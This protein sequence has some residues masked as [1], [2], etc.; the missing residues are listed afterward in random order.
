MSGRSGYVRIEQASR[1]KPKHTKENEIKLQKDTGSLFFPQSTLSTLQNRV[2]SQIEKEILYNDETAL[3]SQDEKIR[4]RVGYAI[5]QTPTIPKDLPSLV[6]KSSFRA[7]MDEKSSKCRNGIRRVFGIKGSENTQ[8]GSKISETTSTDSN[9]LD[10]SDLI[11]VQIQSVLSHSICRSNTTT[12]QL[13]RWLGNRRL[14]EPWGKLGKDPELFDPNGDTLIYFCDAQKEFPRPPPSFR[15]NS[16]IIEAS[17][18][19]VL[20][21]LLRAS[22]TEN[23]IHAA[24]DSNDQ[25]CNNMSTSKVSSYDGLVSYEIFFPA[26]RELSQTEV[27]RH[28][29]T[30]RNV[31][32]LLLNASLVGE[33]IYQ[34]LYDLRDR[35]EEYM[36]ANGDSAG[37]II[38]WITRRGIDDPRQNPSTALSFLAWTE[39]DGVRWEEGW[40]EAYCHAVGMRAIDLDSKFEFLPE[41]GYLSSITK[42]LLDRSSMELQLLVR[43]CEYRLNTFDFTDM[44]SAFDHCGPST[45]TGRSAFAR[46]RKFFVQHYQKV[47]STWPPNFVDKKNQWLTRSLSKRLSQDFAVLYDY[48]VDRAVSWDCEEERAGRKW[49]MKCSTNEKFDPDTPDFPMTDILVSFDSRMGYPHIPH[50]Y[51]L[52]PQLSKA[53]LLQRSS[54]RATKKMRQQEDFMNEKQAAM[55]YQ[56]STNIFILGSKFVTNDLVDAYIQFELGDRPADDDP[57]NARRERWVLIYGV[58]QVLASVSVD[59]PNLR[60]EKYV[61]YHLRTSLRRVPPWPGANQNQLEAEHSNSHCWTVPAQWRTLQPIVVGRRPQ[62]SPQASLSSGFRTSSSQ[63]D[64]VRRVSALPYSS[65]DTE[66]ILS[67]PRDVN[68]SLSNHYPLCISRDNCSRVNEDYFFAVMIDIFTLRIL[69]HCLAINLLRVAY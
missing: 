2:K 1:S 29:V 38:E 47:F 63:Y 10:E 42:K 60:Y 5:A 22:C 43:E 64:G 40:K 53:R 21:K 18:L 51:C 66:S 56:N 34:A 15:L 68:S 44:W 46:L 8:P 25:S 39:G 45:T 57:Y 13:K 52:T 9:N 6:E 49:K 62:L 24:H 33:T 23:V 20:I 26:P 61:D 55:A 30:T 31:F 17:E 11:G 12:T 3:I 7:M 16:H 67:T 59:T 35:V 50:P 4:A 28:Q 65:H 58:L 32:A 36:P 69:P 37:L 41:Y 14:A 27:L 48:L 54:K 19:V